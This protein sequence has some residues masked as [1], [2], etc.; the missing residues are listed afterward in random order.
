M[1]VRWQAYSAGLQCITGNGHPDATTGKKV[2][3]CRFGL[4]KNERTS[5]HDLSLTF[6]LEC[7]D[8]ANT[9]SSTRHCGIQGALPQPPYRF[10]LPLW[11]QTLALDPPVS[12]G[13]PKI[14]FHYVLTALQNTTDID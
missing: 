8:V 12:G 10:E 2:A 5:A 6:D 7:A 3:L 9:G 4:P 14:S 13:A 1:S 11:P